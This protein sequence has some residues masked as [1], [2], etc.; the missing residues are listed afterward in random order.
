MNDDKFLKSVSDELVD[1]FNGKWNSIVEIIKTN[2]C[3]TEQAYELLWEKIFIKH[4]DYDIFCEID[5]QRQVRI[6]STS[7]TVDMILK[8]DDTDLVAIEFKQ[9]NASF[10]QDYLNQLISYIASA[11]R[12]IN[13][14]I[15]LCNQIYIFDYDDSKP[16][17]EQ[18]IVVI[19]FE[20]DNQLGASFVHLFSR[21]AFNLSTIKDW[22]KEHTKQQR[23]IEKI[24]SELSSHLL[25]E[26]L[27]QYFL[28]KYTQSEYE[29]AIKGWNIHISP[30]PSK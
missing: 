6:G 26:L 16:N 12:H 17:D 9:S 3:S 11:L 22:I 18:D 7:K 14:G 19:P 29:E 27:Q 1:I 2:P 4:F 13:I 23:N 30:S 25:L 21:K 24:K 15:V 8:R 20:K 5:R 28:A 10:H